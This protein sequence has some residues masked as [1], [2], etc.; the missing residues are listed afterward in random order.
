MRPILAVRL[1]KFF[2]CTLYLVFDLILSVLIALLTGMFFL[3]CG[4]LYHFVFSYSFD[5]KTGG[6][7]KIGRQQNYIMLRM[8]QLLNDKV[9]LDIPYLRRIGVWSTRRS[10]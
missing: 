9:G 4:H 8:Q 2:D 7:F 3:F 1:M 5:S 10:L 6:A